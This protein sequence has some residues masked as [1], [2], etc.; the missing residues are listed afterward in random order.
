MKK[1]AQALFLALVVAAPV[2]L[3]APVVQAK[4]PQGNTVQGKTSVAFAPA[5]E[6]QQMRRR[7]RRRRRT[8]KTGLTSMNT[9]FMSNAHKTASRGA[10]QA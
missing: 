5:A 1:L 7:R 9:H 4:T 2:A 6:A 10:K 8:R 3:S